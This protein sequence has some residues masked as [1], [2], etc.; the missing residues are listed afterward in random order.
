VAQ[1]DPNAAEVQHEDDEQKLNFGG[2]RDHYR[3]G[4]HGDAQHSQ[5]TTHNCDQWLLPGDV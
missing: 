5:V 4:W 1:P 3:E 2:D